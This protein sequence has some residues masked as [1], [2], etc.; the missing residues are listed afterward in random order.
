MEQFL[1]QLAKQAQIE[2]QP[3]SLIYREH[4][5]RGKDNTSHENMSETLGNNILNNQEM[6]F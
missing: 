1:S 3:T 6:R 4:R 2:L 5:S